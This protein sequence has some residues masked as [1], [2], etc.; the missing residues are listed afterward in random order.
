M[1]YG[2]YIPG[3]YTLNVDPHNIY[4]DTIIENCIH[5]LVDFLENTN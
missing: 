1:T 2:W 5:I 3:L 4:A